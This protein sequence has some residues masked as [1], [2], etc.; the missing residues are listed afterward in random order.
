MLLRQ[1][2]THLRSGHSRGA[3]HATANVDC[4]RARRIKTT[5]LVRSPPGKPRLRHQGTMSRTMNVFIM[6]NLLCAR[7]VSAIP[8]LLE[9]RRQIAERTPEDRHARGSRWVY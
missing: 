2:R 6:A 9:D 4:E 7:D 5:S 8:P 1:E 3:D